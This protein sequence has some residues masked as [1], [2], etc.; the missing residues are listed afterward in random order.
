MISKVMRRRI[1]KVV[2]VER[3]KKREED[4]Q[5]SGVMKRLPLD[6]TLVAA[7]GGPC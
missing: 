1:A 5:D 6:I 7:L 2:D 3:M 4:A